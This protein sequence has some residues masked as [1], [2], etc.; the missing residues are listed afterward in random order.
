MKKEII[1]FLEFPKQN[2]TLNEMF[3]DAVDIVMNLEILF[4]NF[5]SL[6]KSYHEPDNFLIEC[7]NIIRNIVFLIE[8]SKKSK[9]KYSWLYSFI[10]EFISN[11]QEEIILLK[12]IRDNSMHQELLVSEGAIVS[13]LYRINS[14]VEY[15]LKLGMGDVN[16]KRKINLSYVYSRTEKIF[17]KLLFM[18]YYAMIDLE[19]SASGECLGITRFW[20]ANIKFKDISGKTCNQEIDLFEIISN[21]TDK[22]VNGIIDSYSNFKKIK[23]S[24]IVIKIDSE[25]N[26]VNTL[27]EID[28]YPKLLSKFWGYEVIPNNWKYQ[29]DIID[30]KNRKTMDIAMYNAYHHIPKKLDE[31]LILIKR[32]CNIEIENFESQEDYDQFISF[33]LLPHFFVKQ[34]VNLKTIFT[35]D[36]KLLLELQDKAEIF[37][38]SVNEKFDEVSNDFKNK[39]LNKLKLIIKKVYEQIQKL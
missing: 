27:L 1:Y 22:L 9:S 37:I 28:L 4:K 31:L 5:L 17:Q 6:Q 21:V 23:K 16:K 24:N 38:S 18:H 19:H 11:N 12:K 13:G 26:F 20:I 29:I 39:E 34:F 33:I 35:V 25:Y 3:N 15:T 30:Y 2:S 10:K 8:K 32:Y 7:N 14:E 36:L